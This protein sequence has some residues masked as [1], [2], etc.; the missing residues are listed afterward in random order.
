MVETRRSE[1]REALVLA[2]RA[3]GGNVAR[4]ARSIGISRQRAYRLMDGSIEPEAACQSGTAPD[5]DEPSR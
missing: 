2:L 5:T 4:A 3:E 1:E